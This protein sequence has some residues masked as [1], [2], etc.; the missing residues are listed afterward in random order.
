MNK[1]LLLKNSPS[2]TRILTR[3]F[4]TG[5]ENPVADLVRDLYLAINDVRDAVRTWDG[6]WA[7]LLQDG[8]K[9][10]KNDF[11]TRAQQELLSSTEFDRAFGGS[12]VLTDAAMFVG[13]RQ[14]ESIWAWPSLLRALSSSGGLPQDDVATRRSRFFFS[15]DP[16]LRPRA[17]LLASV[18]RGNDVV[19]K[20]GIQELHEHFFGKEGLGKQFLPLLQQGSRV[21]ALY[22]E[23]IIIV[24][25]YRLP[26][27]V[28]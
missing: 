15:G 20:K 2:L 4:E 7:N 9:A 10:P 1:K 21:W 28:H 27:S 22:I 11:K 18:M 14:A 25:R 8:R 17:K 23:H 12:S 3:C 16:D 19:G 6:W 24:T 26:S 5:K 13:G